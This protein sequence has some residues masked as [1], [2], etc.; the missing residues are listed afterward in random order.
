M[1]WSPKYLPLLLTTAGQRVGFSSV[2]FDEVL[3]VNHSLLD[4]KTKENVN[5]TGLFLL[6]TDS[7]ADI[8]FSA[9]NSFFCRYCTRK[10]ELSFRVEN[11]AIII[12]KRKIAI[13]KKKV[14]IKKK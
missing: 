11:V 3:Q 7:N 14:I 9:T 8:H 2:S 6:F 5:T 13:L 4:T 10:E 1:I 12:S